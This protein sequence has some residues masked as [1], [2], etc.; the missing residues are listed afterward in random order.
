MSAEREYRLRRRI[1]QLT[2]QRDIARDQLANL[3]RQARTLRARTL[4]LERSR[5]LWRL[6]A[7]QL[8]QKGR[9]L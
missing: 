5:D 8:A 7:Q 9:R 6:R 1:D 3:R 4:T 2:D